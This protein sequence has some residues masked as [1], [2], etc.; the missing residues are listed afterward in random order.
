M[1]I[2]YI[3]AGSFR[4]SYGL[5]RNFCALSKIIPLD[6]WLVDIDEPLL[7]VMT[8]FLKKI[9]KKHK[10]QDNI[11]VHMTP[12]RREAFEGADIVVKSISIGKQDSEWFDIYVPQKFGIP[13]NTGDTVGPG[14][15]FRTLRTIPVVVDIVQDM[16]DLC[17]NALL[18]N[19]TNPQ[20]TI[21][22]AARKFFPQIESIGICH[23]LFEGMKALHKLLGKLGKKNIPKWENIEIK[24][25]GVNHFAWL[26]S[27]EYQGE[28]LYPL[29][30]ENAKIA[31]KLVGRELN[32]YLL[33]KYGYYNYV[34]ARH[35]AEFIPEFYNFFNRFQIHKSYKITKLRNVAFIRWERKA[36]IWFYRQIS[37]GLM[38][39]PSPTTKGERVIEMAVDGLQ[40]KAG[41]FTNDPPRY[42][43]INIPNTEQKIVSNLPE[44]SILES[45]GYFKDGHVK[46]ISVGSMPNEIADIIKLHIDNTSKSVE[47]AISGNLDVLLKALLA[48]PMCNFIEDEDAVEDMMRNM[49]YYQREWLPKFKESIPNLE[50]LKKLKHFVTKKDLQKKK[51][52]IKVKWEPRIELKEKAFYPQKEK[53]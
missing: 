34:E 12:N 49:L 18:F 52:A 25:S 39:C 47:A 22:Y 46:A 9:I 24:Y 19:Y 14:G 35:V 53:N 20:S 27:C 30:R 41:A 36:A 33:E 23:E 50:D 31:G 37:R 16:A 8:R 44:G 51:Q 17:P 4:F 26:T 15:I 32:F 48:D 13:Q 28:D 11:I 5:F 21:T 40:S 6:I 45:T 7:A 42:H 2:V 29:I 1:K 3:G 43:P 38:P 10:L